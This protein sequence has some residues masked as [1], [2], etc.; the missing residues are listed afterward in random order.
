M[1]LINDDRTDLSLE[2]NVVIAA[3]MNMVYGAE[4]AAYRLSDALDAIREKGTLMQTKK[5]ALNAARR[6]CQAMISNLETAFD[7]PFEQVVTRAGDEYIGQRDAEF[8][9]LACEV[10][11]IVIIF[12][13][14][15]EG[16]P[17]EKRMNIFKALLNFKVTSEVNLAALRK[18]FRF[19]E[20]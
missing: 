9:A 19:K 16:L 7:K 17:Y 14:V 1:K 15:S 10:L 3:V 13:S 2:A 12:L 11:D 4:I 5:R 8:H 18:F 6:N 20:G